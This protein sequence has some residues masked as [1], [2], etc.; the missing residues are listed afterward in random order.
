MCL[1]LFCYA[2][3]CVH[4]SFEIILKRKRK[5]VALVLLS[6]RCVVTINVLW[7]FLTVPW[8][9]MQC[10]IVECIDHTHFFARC[11]SKLF[12]SWNDLI[13]SYADQPLHTLILVRAFVIHSL[14]GI[15]AKLASCKYSI[16]QQDCCWAG[17]FESYLVSPS[18][19]LVQPRKTSPYIT[20]RLMKGRKQSNEKKQASCHHHHHR[21]RRQRH[22]AGHQPVT[23]SCRY[24]GIW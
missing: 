14:E 10:V 17:W 15:R 20:E 16:F 24:V 22:K 11:Y 18:L 5:W 19:V 13:L 4:S 1:Y 23:D 3:L 2:L 7:F 9:D 12:S 6:Y 21:H 8:V